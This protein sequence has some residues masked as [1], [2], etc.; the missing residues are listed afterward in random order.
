MTDQP[1]PMRRIADA[2]RIL[3]YIAVALAAV[4]AA[5]LLF[6]LFSQHET[7]YGMQADRLLCQPVDAVAAARSALVLLFPGVLM[8][9]AAAGALW[10]SRAQAPDARSAAYGLLVTSA[11][12]FVGI[13]IP[14][15]SGAGLFLAPAALVI[16]IVTVLATIK[17][18]SEWRAGIAPAR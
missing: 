16:S 1:T 3:T 4:A 10:H 7:C 14:A 12:L 17:F 5:Y 11:L 15:M 13:I 9:G 18:L 6:M 8:V 2:E